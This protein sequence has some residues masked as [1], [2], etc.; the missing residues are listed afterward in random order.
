MDVSLAAE[1]LERCY[2]QIYF[3]CHRRHVRDPHSGEMLSRHQASVLDHLDSLTGTSVSV[4]AE[5]M[6]VGVSTMS[7]T[8]DRLEA[9]GHVRRS[10]GK[11]DSRRVE[12]RLTAK[13]ERMRAVNSV[14]DPALVRRLVA[15]LDDADRHRAIEGLALLA[16]AAGRL[17]R[18]ESRTD[19]PESS[20]E[21]SRPDAQNRPR[22]AAQLRAKP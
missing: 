2:P 14:L 9:S 1:A 18:E 10:R 5:H 3:C 11:H 6:G 12:V 13:G 16:A 15:S 17:G 4:L 21:G 7:L 19:G 22:G 8:L 20:G